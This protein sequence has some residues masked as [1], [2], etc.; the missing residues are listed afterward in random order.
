VYTDGMQSELQCE[1][2]GQ[3]C[4][5]AWVRKNG[6]HFIEVALCHVRGLQT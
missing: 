4:C 1:S 6:Y 5:V 2:H 3:Q